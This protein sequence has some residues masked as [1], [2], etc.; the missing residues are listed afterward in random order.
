MQV[1]DKVQYTKPTSLETT[2]I[3][4]EIKNKKWA[5]I[6]WSDD[7]ILDEH[8]DDLKLIK[9]TFDK[10]KKSD[11]ISDM[12]VGD[13]V[14]VGPSVGGTYIITSLKAQD[15]HT[16]RPLPTCVMLGQLDGPPCFSEPLP[17]DKKW[18]TLISTC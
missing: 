14:T 13:L 6:A 8:I 12:K 2:G 15:H 11:I 9:K 1:G 16:G 3:V 10:P 4:K 18:I 5:K 17:M 7:I